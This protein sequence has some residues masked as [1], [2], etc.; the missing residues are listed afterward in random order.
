MIQACLTSLEVTKYQLRGNCPPDQVLPG[1]ELL[2]GLGVRWPELDPNLSHGNQDME[3]RK[4][5]LQTYEKH[6]Q[7]KA[8][9]TAHHDQ[10]LHILRHQQQELLQDAKW[11]QLLT[12]IQEAGKTRDDALQTYGQTQQKLAMIVPVLN[13]ITQ[14]I[15]DLAIHP[16]SSQD[17][18]PHWKRAKLAQ[19][20]LEGLKKVTEQVH[21]DLNIPQIT[22]IPNAPDPELET[23]LSKKVE[24]ICNGL[25]V[26]KTALADQ[27]E[28]MLKKQESVQSIISAA[29]E[30]LLQRLG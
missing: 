2:E 1:G 10:A 16:S 19:T 22:N 15:D 9:L 13:M 28:T 18:S 27:Q 26:L 17:L 8:A 30:E 12:E 25:K 3:K 23:S 4:L 29:Q 24:T 5:A 11:T 7:P 6:L 20:L 14:F 21:L